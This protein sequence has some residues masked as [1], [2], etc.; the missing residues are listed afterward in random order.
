MSISAKHY[1]VESAHGI[2][3]SHR[4][5]SWQLGRDPEL[6]VAGGARGGEGVGGTFLDA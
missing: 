3:Q 4:G 5:R 2:L 6:L 1:H